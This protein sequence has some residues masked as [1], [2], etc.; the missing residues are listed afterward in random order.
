MR[1]T[2]VEAIPLRIPSPTNRSALGVFPYH[3]YGLVRV[4]TDEGITGLGEICT[5]WDGKGPV[6]CSFV[7][8]LFGPALVDADPTAINLC[9]RRMDTLSESAW[10]A[11]A[12]VEMALYDIAG[13]A[14]GVPVYQLLGGRTRQSVVL[15]R[16]IYMDAP[17]RMAEAAQ[18]AVAQGYS[19]VKV[20]VGLDPRADEQRVA[21]IRNAI[22]PDVILRVDANMGWRTAKHAIGA[23]KRLEQFDLHSVEQPLPPGNPDELV[24]VRQSVSVP[25][26][27]DESLWGP[28]DA[29]RLLKMGAVDMLNVYVAE[30]GGLTNSSLIFRMAETIRIPCLIGAMP[31]LGIGTSAG[32]HLGVAMTNLNDPCDACGVAYH[33]VDIINERFKIADGQIWPLDGPGLG[34]TLDEDAVQR[35]SRAA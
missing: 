29:W 28:A 30:S 34:V 17:E 32:V 8:E 31:E 35:Y 26:M 1:I 15:S 6:Q 3:D 9:L 33:E 13:K 10:P 4:H 18:A 23:I 22:G 20:K 24:L 19:C 5:L 27:V 11:R 14:F 25:I 16:S 21:A 2:R 7:R 12:A